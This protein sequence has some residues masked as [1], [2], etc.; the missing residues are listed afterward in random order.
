MIEGLQKFVIENKLQKKLDLD[1]AD[2]YDFNKFMSLMRKK[3]DKLAQ[4]NLARIDLDTS[5]DSSEP[6]EPSKELAVA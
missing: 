1:Y 3:R 6:E 2:F 4:N 5:D